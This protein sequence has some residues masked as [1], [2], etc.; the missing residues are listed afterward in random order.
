MVTGRRST[1]AAQDSFAVMAD[2]PPA[3]I[4]END[5]IC[6]ASEAIAVAGQGATSVALVRGP[7]GWLA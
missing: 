3:E 4:G 7:L 2:S 1:L 6:A 5:V